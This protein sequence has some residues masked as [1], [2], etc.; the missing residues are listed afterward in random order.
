MHELAGTPEKGQAKKAENQE[1]E[2]DSQTHHDDPPPS[3]SLAF[4]WRGTPRVYNQLLMGV[5]RFQDKIRSEMTGVFPASKNGTTA[6]RR[7]RDKVIHGKVPFEKLHP[8]RGCP[9]KHR[10]SHL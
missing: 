5:D 10:R 6:C 9:G 4:T 2:K 7:M 3:P 1:K 8:S